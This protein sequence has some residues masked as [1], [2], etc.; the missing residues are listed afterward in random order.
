MKAHSRS[1]KSYRTDHINTDHLYLFFLYEFFTRLR[2]VL[3]VP[4]I[5]IFMSFMLVQ[6]PKVKTRFFYVVLQIRIGPDPSRRFRV[7]CLKKNTICPDFI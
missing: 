7:A 4:N 5:F 1:R 3:W 6:V 2:K